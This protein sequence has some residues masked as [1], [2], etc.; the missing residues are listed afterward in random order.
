MFEFLNK[1]FGV[2]FLDLTYHLKRGHLK[3]SYPDLEFPGQKH[4]G[5]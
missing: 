1:C 2:T 3:I 4:V 5:E